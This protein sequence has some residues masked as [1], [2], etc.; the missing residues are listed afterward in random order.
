MK[1]FRKNFKKILSVFMALAL[2]VPIFVSAI[3]NA[4]GE[5]AEDYKQT[6]VIHKV[7][8]DNLQS[9]DKVDGGKYKDIIENGEY[10]RKGLADLDKAGMKLINGVYFELCRAKNQDPNAK[11]DFEVESYEVSGI[12]YP[13]IL[14]YGNT[15]KG[16]LNFNI[17]GEKCPSG[18][19]IL[20][21]NRDK[22]T[23]KGEGG[24]ILTGMMAAP[25]RLKLPLKDSDG[26]IEKAHLYPKNSEG[27]PSIV[28]FV[29]KLNP[30]DKGD[31]SVKYVDKGQKVYFE[32]VTDI[33][34]NSTLKKAYWTG[35]TSRDFNMQ[36]VA[37]KITEK[38]TEKTLY[39][40][41]D[42]SN[43]LSGYFSS[44]YDDFDGTVHA[45][46][47]CAGEETLKLINNNPKGVQVKITYTGYFTK[48]AGAS[49]MSDNNA[50]FICGNCGEGSK[51]FQPN[52]GTPV[53]LKSDSE[54]K[55]EIKINAYVL[56]KEIPINIYLYEYDAQK[57]E[58]IES[59]DGENGK[60]TIKVVLPDYSTRTKNETLDGLKP[61][62]MYKIKADE[63]ENYAYNSKYDKGDESKVEITYNENKNTPKPLVAES[64]IIRTEG[65]NF[66]KIDRESKKALEGAEFNI[67][68][69]NDGAFLAEDKI[70]G[71]KWV[72]ESEIKNSEV[73]NNLISVKSDSEGKF[74][75]GG[76]KPGEYCLKEIKV[77][78]GYGL[79]DGFA[80]EFKVEK[81]TYIDTKDKGVEV[82]N[83]K[84]EIP[85]TGS[86]GSIIFM[87][88]GI[89]LM[90][91]A[92]LLI[93]TK[94]RTN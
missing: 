87:V 48:K 94:K 27:E 52:T 9:L 66:K 62:T 65:I 40:S 32:M 30:N 17:N 36:D 20:R 11:D 28:S 7:L 34:A 45:H 88:V 79:P 53:V 90:G 82:E 8:Q 50:S 76:I 58:W 67:V 41:T 73:S 23:Y 78:K 5:K 49:C 4:E 83:E 85:G 70:Y 55:I 37:V 64:L 3:S 60:N 6:L 26:I 14:K 84:I 46:R 18:Y 2:I 1:S 77:P 86:I 81:N 89:I 63:V 92:I 16:S 25:M 15:E 57:D 61:N 69:K 71:Q 80:K 56:L 10:L 91:I 44:L 22:S 43:T 35:G 93:N 39:D 12:K 51:D 21:E 33:P 47:I 42:G 54:G 13:K 24:K 31:T 19:Y 68:R 75:V 38:G 72:P 74:T 59:T 29:S